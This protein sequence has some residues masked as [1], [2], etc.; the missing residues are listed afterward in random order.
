MRVQT[1]VPHSRFKEDRCIFKSSGKDDLANDGEVSDG[2]LYVTE[3]W[4][5]CFDT[6]VD[7][8]VQ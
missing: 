3:A 4:S 7:I 8:R 1:F 5:A 2:V 6:H